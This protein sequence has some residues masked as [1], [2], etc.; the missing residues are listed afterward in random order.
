M[1]SIFIVKVTNKYNI[2]ED[3]KKKCLSV[4]T[5]YNRL[6]KKKKT[7]FPLNIVT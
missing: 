4:Y 1:L 3:E 5:Q 2:Y 7:L 6:K